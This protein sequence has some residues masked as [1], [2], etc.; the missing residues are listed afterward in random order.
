LDT[1][2]RALS[3][4]LPQLSEDYHDQAVLLLTEILQEQGRWSES[5]AL[6]LDAN[7]TPR[8][9]LATVFAILAEHRT[10]SSSS[11]R[12]ATD[13]RHLLTTITRSAIPSL[14]VK[15]A[16]AA[17]RLIADLRDEVLGRELVGA[18]DA[19]PTTGLEDHE[20]IQLASAKV[21]LLYH[22]NDRATCL[23]E[24]LDLIAKLEKVGAVNATL[25]NLYT[26]L[27]AIRC[28]EGRY[29]DA[30]TNFRRAFDL[31]V[32]IGN[33]T[34]Q[35][36]IAAQ[37][38]LCCGRLGNYGDQVAWSRRAAEKLDA[39]FM[40]YNHVQAA[41]YGSF[42]LAMRGEVRQALDVMSKAATGIPVS[43]PPWLVQAWNLAR[44]DILYLCGQPANAMSVAYEATGYPRPRLHA[45][46]LAGSF[47]RWLALIGETQPGVQIA[48]ASIDQLYGKLD[49]FDALDQVEIVCARN[50]C[51][52][53][54]QNQE[55]RGVEIEE[56]MRRLPAAVG[57]QLRRLGMIR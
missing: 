24:L 40:G 36:N 6:L 4:A 46:S 19:I 23:Q 11:S 8:S 38:A 14:R 56:R 31:F 17:A 13:V 53:V 50:L 57:E 47:A 18:V 25:A 1:A 21:Q 16:Q 34:V 5:T 45:T 39:S 15:A 28:Y 55:R 12:L 48:A 51:P 33:E 42:A 43:T 54:H 49:R 3:T 35:G 22:I 2:E 10:T 27:G 30:S 37:I 9:E 7:V 26:G 20:A 29:D 44:A 32:R 41:Y 52:L